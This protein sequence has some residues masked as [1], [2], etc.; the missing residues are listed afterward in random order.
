MDSK[1]KNIE[2]DLDLD[3]YISMNND[4]AARFKYKYEEIKNHFLK[5]GYQ[6]NRLYSKEQSNLFYFND[7]IKYLNINEDI[8]NQKINNEMLAFKHYLEHGKNEKRKIYPKQTKNHNSVN[9][10][11]QNK[12]EIIDL[13]F[14]KKMNKEL[15]N[16]S[17]KEIIKYI[18]LN[19]KKEFLLFTI[20]HK[21][22]YLN[23]DWELY[24]KDYPDLKIN[25]IFTVKDAINHFVNFGSKEG[26]T[27]KPIN[28]ID[29][30]AKKIIKDNTCKNFLNKINENNE[31]LL[32]L[33]KNN[34]L[35]NSNNLDLKKYDVAD[36]KDINKIYEILCLDFDYKY[37]Y[38]INSIKYELKNEEEYC[39][40]HFFENGVKNYLP[41]SKSHYLLLLNYKW[42][43]FSIENKNNYDSY[44]EYI[45][46][47]YYY[48]ENIDLP[49]T[50]YPINQFINEFYNIAYGCSNEN[51][52][53]SYKNFLKNENKNKIFPNLFNYF[54]YSIIN[55]DSFSKDNNLDCKLFEMIYLLKESEYDFSK[56]KIEFNTIINLNI[57]DKKSL[58]NL[59]EFNDFYNKI[60]VYI[61]NN[62]S[63]YNFAE[64]NKKFK[65]L[66]N[67]NLFDIPKKFEFMN[68]I[69]YKSNKILNLNIIINYI[70][71]Y[72]SLYTLLLSVFYQNCNNY[73]IIILNKCSDPDIDIKIKEIKE[74]LN[75][76]NEIFI[77]DNDELNNNLN[78]YNDLNKEND[79]SKFITLKN[80]I[81][82]FDIN[83]LIDTNHYFINNNVDR[84]SVV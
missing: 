29:K 70:N 72:D 3:F 65:K 66:F 63:I 44:L 79:N 78:I 57:P 4:V 42:D 38:K 43:E 22:L 54:L 83:L 9:I 12:Y 39:I 26:R 52:L 67:K 64:I 23:Y 31:N 62:K 55:W 36:I 25:K 19:N 46:L 75:I 6:E 11:S 27:I 15:S 2:N 69:P 73:K 81:R 17:E 40:N 48:N 5:V 16:L 13:D 37:Y 32:Q 50:K 53:I 77:I 8:I 14:A 33:F 24:L 41:Y 49:D 71:K 18:D 34:I 45:K 76:S 80:I 84:K 1:N 10:T 82:N 30:V 68:F 47:T 61:K 60:V 35:D 20:N 21:N 7:W 59:E 58:V 51:I 28:K 74:S 56:Y